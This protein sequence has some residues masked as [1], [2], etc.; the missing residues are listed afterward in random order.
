MIDERQLSRA[1]GDGLE[2]KN[3]FAGSAEATAGDEPRFTHLV[4]VCRLRRDFPRK[5]SARVRLKCD[6][7]NIPGSELHGAAII[8]FVE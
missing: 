5:A 3:H 6:F 2:I 7:E 8:G 1:E 4:H